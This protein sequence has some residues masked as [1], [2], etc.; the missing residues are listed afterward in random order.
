MRTAPQYI[1][2]R[3]MWWVGQILIHVEHTKKITKNCVKQKLFVKF[4]NG[5]TFR[6]DKNIFLKILTSHEIYDLILFAR[7]LWSSG[8]RSICLQQKR[9]QL[10]GIVGTYGLQ[11][12]W[13]PGESGLVQFLVG[14]FQVKITVS[15]SACCADL[16]KHPHTQTTI[17]KLFKQVDLWIFQ[18]QRY[19]LILPTSNLTNV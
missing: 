15:S 5:I 19:L 16:T 11:K 8:K 7:N 18:L 13:M 6:L 2:W 12:I 4:N 10:K 9:A 3:S 14:V 17:K 1:Y